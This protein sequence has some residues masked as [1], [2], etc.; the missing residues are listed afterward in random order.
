M[1]T[2]SFY[3]EIMTE[4]QNQSALNSLTTINNAQDLLTQVTSS[5]KA[6]EHNLWAWITAYAMNILNGLFQLFKKDVQTLLDAK[7]PGTA[8]WY[9]QQMLSF[10]Y[11]FQLIWINNQYNYN[12]TT[13]ALALAARVIKYC[14]VDGSQ[15]KVVFKV[16][17]ETAGEPT[18]LP[19]VEATAAYNYMLKKRFAGSKIQVIALPPDVLRVTATIYYDP[20]LTLAVVKPAVE[21]TIHNFNKLIPFNGK[22]NINKLNDDLQS[23]PGVIDPVISL[24]EYKSGS[25]PYQQVVR[26]YQTVGGYVKI[27]T[28]SGNTL[29]DTITYLPHP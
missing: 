18:Q 12:D 16:A 28:T 15:G 13:S 27:D 26:E 10:Q 14:A 3:E 24:V 23:T 1:N 25:N 17:G 19:L 22:F 20:L 2:Q 29:N 21:N 11:N 9:R 7:E 4:K 5:S 6:A 8:E